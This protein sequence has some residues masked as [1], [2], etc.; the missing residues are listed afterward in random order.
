MGGEDADIGEFP[1]QVSLRFAEE[2]FCGGALISKRHVL[3]AG[4][5]VYAADGALSYVTAVVGTNFVFA[6]GNTYK[7]KALDYHPKYNPDGSD[8]MYDIGVVTVSMIT[9]VEDLLSN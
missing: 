8:W 5:C 1:Y 2:H 4:H 3:T 6:R 7:V 9:Y